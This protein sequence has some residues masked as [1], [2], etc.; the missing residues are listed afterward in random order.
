MKKIIAALL[1]STTLTGCAVW[2]AYFMAKYDNIEYA[3]INKIR[4]LSE[5]STDT[6]KD[7]IISKDNFN[8]MYFVAV[9]LNNFSQHVPRNKDTHKISQ[10]LVELTKQGKEMYA[11]SSNVSETF[12]KIKLQ[13]INRS[14]ELAQKVIGA[15]PR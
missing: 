15:K 6:C 9:E 4:T 2:D 13:Q 14:A 3:L 12:C 1:L 10:N 8:A 5:L 7:T 11:K